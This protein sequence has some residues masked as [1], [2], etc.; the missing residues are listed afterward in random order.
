MGKLIDLTGE[1]F[2]I[3][4]VIRKDP[5]VYPDGAH[6]ICECACGTIFSPSGRNLRSKPIRSCGCKSLGKTL[7]EGEAASNALYR[8]YSAR[9][10]KRGYFFGL[11]LEEFLSLTSGDCKYCGAVPSQIATARVSNYVYNGI[12]RV[13]NYKG[14]SLENCVACCKTCNTAKMELSKREYL[15]H[16]QKVVDYNG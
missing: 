16:C 8:R 11:S 9:A 14:Y 5:K 3:V 1:E 4:T 6:W 2:G 13:D 10:E 15:E 7:K 12:D